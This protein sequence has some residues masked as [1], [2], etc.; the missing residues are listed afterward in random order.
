MSG[1]A[2]SFVD[3]YAS[4]ASAEGQSQDN[5]HPISGE[6]Q[7]FG[8]AK[9]NRPSPP[10]LV[11]RARTGDERALMYSYMVDID[12]NPS[13]GIVIRFV[14]RKVTLKGRHLRAI[15]QRLVDHRVAWVQ[16][17]DEA[18]VQDEATTAVSAIEIA[19]L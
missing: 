3:K 7:C 4:P 15:F 17:I 9:E 10:M 8:V 18:I 1:D 5:I 2:E 19:E 6:L 13:H 16:E 14:N 12:F 11:L